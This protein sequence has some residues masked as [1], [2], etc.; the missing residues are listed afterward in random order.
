MI[1]EAELI[2]QMICSQILQINWNFGINLSSNMISN[3]IRQKL[4]KNLKK[5]MKA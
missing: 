2:K 1:L 3:K 4:K 5:Y